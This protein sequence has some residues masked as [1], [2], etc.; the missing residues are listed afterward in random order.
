M[1][2]CHPLSINIERS[3]QRLR[4]VPLYYIMLL[5]LRTCTGRRNGSVAIA[6]G[7]ENTRSRQPH[8]HAIKLMFFFIQLIPK[9][10]QH[11]R[12]L[13]ACLFG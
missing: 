9:L 7:L 8:F 4:E 13:D 11:N 1:P 12:D 2:T 10:F 5:D 6:N 3:P